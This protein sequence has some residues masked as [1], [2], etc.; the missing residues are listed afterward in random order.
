MKSYENQDA[1]MTAEL[2]ALRAVID[3]PEF[4]DEL[5]E[6]MFPHKVMGSVMSA[7]RKLRDSGMNL[8]RDSIL[9]EAMN[10]DISVCNE[11]VDA[12][13]GTDSVTNEKQVV[14]RLRSVK[15]V[16]DLK[17]AFA[18][19]CEEID[20]HGLSTSDLRAKVVNKIAIMS[21]LLAS[22]ETTRRV[23]DFNEWFEVYEEEAK[24][25]AKGKKYRF[26][27]QAFD[28][29][30]PQGPTPGNGGLIVAGTGQ[31][32]SAVAL[33]LINNLVDS[34]VPCFYFS[35]EMG[36]MD[37]MDR[38]LS[39]RTKI[40]FS[41]IVNP[42]AEDYISVREAI[43][44][45]RKAM[46]KRDFF[47]FSE[48]ASLSLMD[49]RREI[50]K[51]M[52]ETGVGYCVVVF[53]LLSMVRDFYRISDGTNFAQ[54]AEI[55]INR[56]NAIA[57]ELNFHW[58]GILQLNRGAEDT[59]ISDI[60]DIEHTRPQRNH[61]KNANAY[62]ERARWAVSVWRPKF[63]AEAYLE[64]GTHDDLEDIVHIDSLKASNSAIEH[65]KMM[66]DGTTFSCDAL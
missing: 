5:S 43:D 46:V 8:D 65:D 31:G 10:I 2:R 59:R 23:Y 38:W 66:F 25:R 56:L 48:S 26:N 39:L 42:S 44:K 3:R 52:T 50:Q 9:M 35:L 63:F 32:K 14:D 13:I 17:T 62:L 12:I 41:T 29:I 34:D 24:E 49:C 18:E 55:G 20:S 16:R 27:N 30:V 15:S 1:T 22:D 4:L 6:D 57:K 60:K 47:R 19:V 54:V 51:F 28:K 36:K 11:H 40:P 64:P 21:D 61:I 7:M 45:E 33:N 37:T 53:D 58:I